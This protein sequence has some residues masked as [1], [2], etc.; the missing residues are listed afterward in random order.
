MWVTPFHYTPKRSYC[1]QSMEVVTFGCYKGAHKQV[2]HNCC[3]N[4]RRMRCT[5]TCST[6]VFAACLGT[7]T[8][9]FSIRLPNT[10]NA[11]NNPLFY[12]CL[13]VASWYT[14]DRALLRISLAFSTLVWRLQ[15]CRYSI[16]RDRERQNRERMPKRYVIASGI[17]GVVNWE[18]R[19]L[20][21]LY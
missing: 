21:L 14:Y 5:L 1:S 12:C 6:V 15:E 16:W 20:P 2:L 3:K 19:T 4:G 9:Q 18:S 7:N 8:H 17:S 11:T 10:L 13:C